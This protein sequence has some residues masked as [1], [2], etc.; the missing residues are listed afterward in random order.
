[1][2]GIGFA[3]PGPFDYPGGIGLFEATDKYDCLR[4]AV[5]P[6][7]L[8]PRLRQ[9]PPMRFINDATAFGISMHR[10]YRVG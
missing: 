4:D 8:E 10:E 5:V 1:M 3:M 7:L 6:E 9:A 2:A